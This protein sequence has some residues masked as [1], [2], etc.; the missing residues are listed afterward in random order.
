[1]K[2]LLRCFALAAALA[3]LVSAAQNYPTRA[4]RLM[5]PFPPGGATDII[6]RLVSAKMQDVWGQPVVVE[7]RPGAGTVVGTDYVAKSAPDGY[8][9]GMVV[10]AYVINPSLR[11]DL[12]YNTLKDLTG[13]T[14]VSVQHLVM[15]ANPSLPAS[16]VPEL[17]ALAKKNPGKLA[18]ATP[19]SGTAMHLSVEML[20]TSAGVDLVHVPYK[21]GA[22]AQQDVVAGHVPILM[23]V[24]YAVQPLI[25]SGKI[26]VLALLSP[27]RAP[28]SPEY[29]VV[30]EAVPGVSALSIVGIVVAAATPRELVNRISADIARAVR[31]SDLTERMKQQGM[32]P[33]G[34]MP[35]EFD[36]LIRAEIEKWAKVV[37]ASGAKVD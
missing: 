13:V 35:E 31:S 27:Q 17:I 6:G 12:P 4:V 32:E 25:K 2:T 37:K 23:D 11:T 28:E 22:P 8:T 5:V 29:P 19:G 26:K 9:L 36:A 24:L 18:Y 7:N 33:V 15:A 1:M 14:Q 21:G 20:K 16:S 30:A 3:P 10:T 34:S